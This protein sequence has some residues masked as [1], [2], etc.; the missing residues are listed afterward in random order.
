MTN[1]RRIA[2]W[3]DAEHLAADWMR[4]HGFPDARVTKSGADNGID[5]FSRRAIAQVKYQA[6]YV[7][8][9]QVQQLVGARGPDRERQLLFFTGSSYTGTALG[10]ADVM[11]IG[12]FTYELDGT[13]TP[14]NS[15]A[16]R[17][18]VKGRARRAWRGLTGI[19]REASSDSDGTRSVSGTQG[20]ATS[21]SVIVSGGIAGIRR[22]GAVRKGDARWEEAERLLARINVS[23]LPRA[24][25]L[26][27][28]MDGLVYAFDLGGTGY[29]LA[30]WQLTPE[31]DRLA[32]L[33]LN[34]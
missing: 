33:V 3:Q 10:Y 6:A 19:L 27:I 29:V 28:Q 16:E 23:E 8:R 7:G 30:D 21:I 12:L 24:G 25:G 18:A 31:L 34:V 26:P 22:S 4:D 11:S 14:A 1:S 2:S 13:V 5:V 15:V 20:P 32:S 9:P 17:I